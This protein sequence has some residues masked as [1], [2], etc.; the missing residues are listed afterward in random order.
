MKLYILDD[1]GR[2]V[3]EFSEDA[4]GVV[5]AVSKETKVKICSLLKAAC[6]L[7]KGQK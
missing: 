4:G 6:K 3:F 5:L 1:N 7:V 2:V